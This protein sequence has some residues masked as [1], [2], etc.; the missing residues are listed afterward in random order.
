MAIELLITGD[1]RDRDIKRAQRDVDLLKTQAGTTGSAF[2]KMSGFA[3]GMGA[4]V[5]AAAIGAAAAGARMALEF[6]VNGVKAFVEDEAAAA[7]LAQTMSNLGM[8]GA[9]AAVEANIDALQRQFGVADDLLRPSMEKLLR[10]FGD[11]GTASQMMSLALDISAGTGRSL[12]QVTQALS[13]AAGGNALALGK[14]APELDKNILKSGDMNAITAELS[15]TFGGQART[16]SQTYQ[17][18]LARLAVGFGELQ[19]SFGAGFIK[20]LGQ[21][22]G[23]TGDLM[24]AMQD[25]QPALEEVGAAA[26]DLVLELAGLVTA[27]NKA[28]KAG[29]SFLEDPNWDDLGTTIIEAAKSNEFFNST[30]VN[31]I[32]VIGPTINFLLQLTGAYDALAGSAANAYGG[33]SRTAMAMG[34]GAPIVDRNSAATARYTGLA[35]ELGATVSTT[36]GNLDGFFTSLQSVGGGAS[37]A[38]EKIVVLTDKQRNLALTM[39]GSQVALKQATDDLKAIKDAADAY[40]ESTTAAILGTV[41]LSTAFGDAMKASEEGSLAAGQTVVQATIANLQ[42]QAEAS[43]AFEASLQAIVA[44]GGPA[45]MGLIEMLR[46]TARDHGM[47]AGTLLATEVLTG[48]FVPALTEQLKGFNVFATD[49]GTAMANNF[50]GQGIADADALLNGLSAEV[51]AQAKMLDRLGRNIGLPIAAAI[52][53]EIAQAIR[54]GIADGRAVAARRRAQAFAAASFV[55]ITVAPGAPGAAAFTGGGMVNIAPMAAGG[56]VAG[57]RPFLVGERGPELFVPGSNGN[58]VPNN[59]MGGNTYQITVQAGVGDPRAIGQSIVEYVRKFE[60][61]NGPVFRA[62]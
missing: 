39:A 20:A 60:Q 6:G 42:A 12:E 46:Q 17:G 36:G 61:A 13:R 58:I 55:P 29:K 10:S 30:L 4:A 35:K 32:P 22:E 1:Y 9:T 48:G 41:S 34:K 18:Q 38:A 40:A 3:A 24:T 7:K 25:L 57:G 53:E 11:V 51:A 54:D 49:A 47:P 23:K 45:T 26:A 19:E 52:S 50:F 15:Q 21:T 44:A 14:I 56:P 43:K 28:S 31:S 37:S 27:S 62:A 33:V 59:A 5:G 2:T 16:A 8:E